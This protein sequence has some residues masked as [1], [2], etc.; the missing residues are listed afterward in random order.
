MS[1]DTDRC[2]YNDRGPYITTYS[3]QKFYPDTCE[4]DHIPIADIAHA[5]SQNCRYNGHLEGFY[6][7]A[8]HS[9]IVSH[10]CHPQQALWGLLHDVTE[11]F[12]PD[13]PRPLKPFIAGFDDFEAKIMEQV[14]KR[15]HLAK[16][17]PESVAYI[18]KHIVGEEAAHMFREPPDWIRFYD[19]IPRAA[20][21]FRNWGPAAAEHRFLERYS[22]LMEGRKR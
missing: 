13:I 9:I 18:D 21:M 2:D 17:M 1:H 14:C 10:L 11:A 6:S 15:W 22:E 5:L 3:G 20:R 4:I 8:E 7:V 19:R 16:E 12:V